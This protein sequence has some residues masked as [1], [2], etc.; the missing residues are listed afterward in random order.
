[1]IR[2]QAESIDVAELIDAVRDP[3][4]GAA[5][6]FLGTVRSPDLGRRVVRLEY[7][8]YEPMAIA[9]L[10]R[11]V[12]ATTQRH[13]TARVAV[14][15]RLGPVIP[16]EISVAIAVSAAHR[17]EAFAACQLIIDELKLRVPIWKREVFE[18]G[19]NWVEGSS[20]REA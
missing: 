16:G 5:V 8:A 6:Q 1:M 19:A 14:V 17:A 7:E 4:A 2:L 13:V 12:Q 15:H 3:A 10:E 20:T 18:D 9:E 11:L